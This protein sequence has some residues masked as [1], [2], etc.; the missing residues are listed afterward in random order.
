MITLSAELVL[1][2]E[3]SSPSQAAE[4]EQEFLYRLQGHDIAA[5]DQL[6]QQFHQMIGNLAYRLTGDSEDAADVTQ[7]VFLKVYQNIG[8]FHSDSSLKTWIYRITVNCALNQKRWWKRR[9]KGQT[10]TLIEEPIKNRENQATELSPRI[11]HPVQE[12][13]VYRN[14]LM[15]KM[16]KSLTS[17]PSDQRVSVILRDMGGMAYE[18]IASMLNLSIGTVK[19]RIARGRETIRR[20]L[21]IYLKH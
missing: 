18:E 19:S 10:E 6:F 2:R 21:E 3:I 1:D 17:L 12:Q 8:T 16:Q 5:F 20:E 11:V 4:E 7:E 9:K 15:E 13:T 14:E